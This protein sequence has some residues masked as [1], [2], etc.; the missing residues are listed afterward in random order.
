MRDDSRP[1]RADRV[2][3]HRGEAELVLLDPDDGNYYTLNEVGARVW[4]LCD[5][6]RRVA[7][8]AE[9]LHQ[10]FDA[11]ADEIERDLAELLEELAGAKLVVDAGS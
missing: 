5:G 1:A 8:I 9:T 2:L 11:P 4:E 7:E 10:E 6:Q 3:A